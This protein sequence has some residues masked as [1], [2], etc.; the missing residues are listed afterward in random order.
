M[1]GVNMR[2]AQSLAKKED[3]KDSKSI[4]KRKSLIPLP[5]AMCMALMANHSKKPALSSGMD[6]ST[7]RTKARVASQT[8]AVM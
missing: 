3:I 6:I 8:R 5:P 2:A 1:M 4:R 7:R